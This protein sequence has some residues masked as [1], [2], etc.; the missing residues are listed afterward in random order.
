[1]I[2]PNYKL[3][4]LNRTETTTMLM[5]GWAWNHAVRIETYST[6]IVMYIETDSLIN[7]LSCTHKCAVTHILWMRYRIWQVII[8]VYR[9]TINRVAHNV[10][11]LYHTIYIPVFESNYALYEIKYYFITGNTILLVHIE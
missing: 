9:K 4:K 5:S 6:I 7:Y 2:L 8:R 3:T 1:M 10:V 11:F